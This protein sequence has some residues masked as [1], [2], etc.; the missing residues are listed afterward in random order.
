[1]DKRKLAGAI[2]GVIAFVALIAGATF[3]WLTRNVNVTNN[4]FT[5][6]TLNF[7]VDYTK[8]ENISN[9][10]EFTSPTPSTSGLTK[11]TVKAGKGDSNLPGKLT[12]TLNTTSTSNA[13][14]TDGYIKYGYCIGTCSSFA[15]TGT[16]NTTSPINIITNTALQDSV[17]DYNI[18][19]WYDGNMNS[20]TYEGLNYKG[21]ITAS[22]SQT[23]S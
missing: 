9:L 13:I 7:I 23:E 4:A 20:K 5:G 16:V 11:I 19:F 12:I 10:K 18:Y 1:M 6:N 15:G 21:N 22:A 3:A 17:T 8:G 2:I 14:I